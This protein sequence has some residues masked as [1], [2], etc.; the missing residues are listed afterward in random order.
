[1][2]LRSFH[3]IVP[4]CTVLAP[5]QLHS[6]HSQHLLT[7]P[8][9]ISFGTQREQL[10]NLSTFFAVQTRRVCNSLLFCT[11]DVRCEAF[12]WY[13]FIFLIVFCF[14]DLMFLRPWISVT[15]WKGSLALYFDQMSGSWFFSKS[16]WDIFYIISFLSQSGCIA[17]FGMKMTLLLSFPWV[18]PTLFPWPGR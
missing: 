3:L 7:L 8:F 16:L 13:S 14:E 9:H 10:G 5:S 12:E 1:M 4:V 17:W 2:W 18:S 11:W 6:R 15:H